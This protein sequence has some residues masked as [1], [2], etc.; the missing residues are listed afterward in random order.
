M[1]LLQPAQVDQSA[2]MPGGLLARSLPAPAGWE[3]GGLL[4]PFYGCGEPVLRDK[5]VQSEDVPNQNA[6]AASFPAVPIEQGSMCSTTGSD[7]VVGSAQDRYNATADWA[8]SRQLQTDQA[9]TGAPKLDDA[10]SMG[11]MAGGDFATALG[12]LEQAAA[13]ELG[14]GA[15]WV[16]HTTLRGLNYLAAASLL[17]GNGRTFAG[18]QVIVGTGY[19]ND[20]GT[21][22]P[23]WVTGQV[24]A[25]IAAPETIE[26]VVYRQNNLEG[27]ARGMGVVAFDG[28]ML[29]KVAVTVPACP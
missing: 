14:F 7:S 6:P 9:D 19:T 8:L 18:A 4:I 21:T 2:R 22:V 20:N 10:V 24:W 15:V 1:V 5:C 11:T 29:G 12:C 16:I 28:C 13:S 27:W 26:G 25:S 3:R 23:L 17:D